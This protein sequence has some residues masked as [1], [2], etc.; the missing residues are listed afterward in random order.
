MKFI[1]ERISGK[2]D[3]VALQ[4]LC[5]YVASL[6]F[7]IQRAGEGV[8]CFYSAQTEKI[9]REVTALPH[10][11]L[12][13]RVY[14]LFAFF[15]LLWTAQ[16]MAFLTTKFRLLTNKKILLIWH[17][18]IKQIN[19]TQKDGYHMPFSHLW[20]LDFVQANKSMHLIYD[21]TVEVNSWEEKGE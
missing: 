8:P 17:N 10:P 3:T 7:S 12:L 1:L 11:F 20:F 5:N 9:F 14:F 21:G 19:L 6:L 18:H 4:G 13:F 2:C 15:S 16:M